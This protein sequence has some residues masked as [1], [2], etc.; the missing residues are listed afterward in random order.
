MNPG[1]G[2]GP[3]R[4]HPTCTS[5]PGERRMHLWAAFGYEADLHGDAIVE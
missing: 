1:I 2:D 4:T 5:N 3:Q